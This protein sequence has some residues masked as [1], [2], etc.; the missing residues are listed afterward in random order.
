MC[1]DQNQLSLKLLPV[2]GFTLL[3]RSPN[4]YASW[5]RR[6]KDGLKKGKIIKSGGKNK[7][8]KGCEKDGERVKVEEAEKIGR[9]DVCRHRMRYR[10]RLAIR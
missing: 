5:Q 8:E 3:P 10:G 1:R 7:G 4:A 9:R 6:R 2:P